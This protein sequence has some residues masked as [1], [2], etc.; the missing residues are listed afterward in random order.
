MARKSTTTKKGRP[1]KGKRA[2]T[3]PY[4]AKHPDFPL[5]YNPT[6]KQL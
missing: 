6:N 2:A 1:R 5:S 3:H 4:I